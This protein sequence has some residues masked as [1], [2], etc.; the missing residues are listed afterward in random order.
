MQIEKPECNTQQKGRNP[1]PFGLHGFT[2]ARIP[3]AA[4]PLSTACR[5]LSFPFITPIVRPKP[6]SSSSAN[7]FKY[8]QIS[9]HGCQRDSGVLHSCWDEEGV[10]LHDEGSV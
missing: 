3:T 1:P 5:L 6:H 2:T 10:C 4:P 8:F 9:G 7:S